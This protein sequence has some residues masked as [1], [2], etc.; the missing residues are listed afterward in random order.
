[1]IQKGL[2]CPRC[3]TA[4]EGS[5]ILKIEK[6]QNL[7][8][9]SVPSHR[10]R[11]GSCPNCNLPLAFGG[12]KISAALWLLALVLYVF[13]SLLLD[14]FPVL[15]LGIVALAMALVPLKLIR[16][17]SRAPY[18]EHTRLDRASEGNHDLNQ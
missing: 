11:R 15:A 10:Y 2:H 8:W 17:V 18:N 5:H 7:R 9:Y 3:E 14:G 16:A 1:M 13:G 6:I 4:L 12:L